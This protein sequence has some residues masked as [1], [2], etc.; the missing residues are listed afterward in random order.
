MKK[1]EK[2]KNENNNVYKTHSCFPIFMSVFFKSLY[3]QAGFRANKDYLFKSPEIRRR[4]SVKNKK[5]VFF[6]L[7]FFNSITKVSFTLFHIKYII[8]YFQIIITITIFRSLEV[9]I[10]QQLTN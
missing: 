6:F 5:K 9:K 10:Q 2:K 4:K 7:S 8:F 1:V 3:T